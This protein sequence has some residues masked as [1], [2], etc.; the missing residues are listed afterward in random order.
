M[1]A[2]PASIVISAHQP[3]ALDHARQSEVAQLD[4]KC[5]PGDFS[6]GWRCDNHVILARRLGKPVGY[7]LFRAAEDGSNVA[8][9]TRVGC[10][11]D[12]RGQG[13]ARKLIARS[14]REAK[15]RGFRA[16]VTYCFTNN[17]ASANALIAAGFRICSL[18]KPLCEG[19]IH[20]TRTLG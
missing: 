3:F 2:A 17:P 18:P 4:W 1:S 16:M 11:P 5:F 9:L 8:F 15:A 6:E 12:E 13:L 14:F 10:L 20:F 19:A 7:V